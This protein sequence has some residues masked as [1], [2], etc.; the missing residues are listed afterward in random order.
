MALV[1]LSKSFGYLFALI[2]LGAFWLLKPGVFDEI[3]GGGIVFNLGSPD[4]PRELYVPAVVIFVAPLALRFGLPLIL[5][6]SLLLPFVTTALTRRAVRRGPTF[7]P[8]SV[9]DDL[10]APGSQQQIAVDRAIAAALAARHLP[11]E[12]PAS[13]LAPS[14]APPTA[15]RPQTPA[16]ILGRRDTAA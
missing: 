6:G 16:Y 3:L 10:F 4:H 5:K 1:R 11:P 14:A 15:G 2:A 12:A 7:D 8:R 9:A 13:S